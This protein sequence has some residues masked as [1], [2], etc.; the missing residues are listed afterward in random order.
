LALILLPLAGCEEKKP[1]WAKEGA[2]GS[3]LPPQICSQVK[4]AL[5]AV[6]KNGGDFT[7]KGEATLPAAVWDQM[8]TEHRDQFAKTVAYHASCAAGAAS[9]GQ[10]VAIRADDGSVL[11][12]RTISTRVDMSE[13]LGP[14]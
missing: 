11:M 12:R 14:E 10:E 9:D 6:A 7:D 3:A 5:E 1:E 4:K 13:I 2:A 8:A